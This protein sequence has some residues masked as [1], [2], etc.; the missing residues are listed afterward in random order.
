MLSLLS[1][2]RV[3]LTTSIGIIFAIEPEVN[4]SLGNIC[5]EGNID[6]GGNIRKEELLLLLLPKLLPIEWQHIVRAP[7]FAGI[8]LMLTPTD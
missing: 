4:M 5:C 3:A 6:C 8:Y 2:S 7:H 1:F